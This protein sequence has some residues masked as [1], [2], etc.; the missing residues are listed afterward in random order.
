MSLPPEPTPSER[1]FR[2]NKRRKIFRRREES[3]EPE[4]PEPVIYASPPVTGPDGSNASINRDSSSLAKDAPIHQLSV[5][6][7]VRQ[8]RPVRGR[9]GGLEFTR[10]GLAQD[11]LKD[12]VAGAVQALTTMEDKLDV[13]EAVRGRF[14]PQ[15]GAVAETGN[16]HM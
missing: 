3:L 1:L 11:R 6:D 15:T 16:Q 2:A 12:G 7:I 8:R 4:T 9:K 14:A 5:L 10:E 13:L